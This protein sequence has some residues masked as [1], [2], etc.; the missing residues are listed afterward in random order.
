METVLSPVKPPIRPNSQFSVNFWVERTYQTVS[1]EV[2]VPIQ[3]VPG[4]GYVYP[5]LG[6]GA[7]EA[8]GGLSALGL[9]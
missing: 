3:K 7:A 2:T 9:G 6:V 5:E 4:G 8:V 1:S